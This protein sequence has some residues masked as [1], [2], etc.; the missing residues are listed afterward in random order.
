MLG[1]RVP[2]VAVSPFSK[3][4]YVSHQTFSHSSVL[5]LI[6]A[7]FGLKALS[8]RDANATPPFDLFDFENPTYKEP[9]KLPEPIVDEAFL[10]KCAEKQ[11]EYVE[12]DAEGGNNPMNK[13]L[14]PRAF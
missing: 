1:F 5:R 3:P 14:A 9:P 7:R 13:E 6:E 2:F 12:P 10:E 4:H 8:R 11:G